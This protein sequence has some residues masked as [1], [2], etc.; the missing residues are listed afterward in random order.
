MDQ[1]QFN[2]IV[3]M[4]ENENPN[5]GGL[6]PWLIILTIGTGL[7]WI[8]FVISFG[9]EENRFFSILVLTPIMLSC[10]WILWGRDNKALS[11]IFSII[12]V[13]ITLVMALGLF[14]Y[15]FIPIG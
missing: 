12:Q 8:G 10:S 7:I 3:N 14:V 9:I 5:I 2:A 4:G 15:H 1:E 11:I 13:L 6:K